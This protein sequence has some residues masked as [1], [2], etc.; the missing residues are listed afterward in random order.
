MLKIN[1]TINVH[2]TVYI[3]ANENI[4]I[5][6]MNATVN[7]ENKGSVN[8]NTSIVNTEAYFANKEEVDMDIK[9]FND[10]VYS[11]MENGGTINE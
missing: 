1:K 2:G 10:Y 9:E 7:S 8:I 6:Q 4:P 3:D 11:V 5:A